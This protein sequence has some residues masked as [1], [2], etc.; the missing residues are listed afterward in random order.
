MA[1]NLSAAGVKQTLRY[2]QGDRNGVIRAVSSLSA[3]SVILSV[4]KD[5][6][7]D[8][9]EDSSAGVLKLYCDTVL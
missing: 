1:V 5:L 4:A 6:M 9:V 7:F 8:I 2:A 3:M